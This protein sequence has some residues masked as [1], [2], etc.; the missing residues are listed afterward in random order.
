M[1]LERCPECGLLGAH[2]PACSKIA[3]PPS[4]DSEE[5]A[6][7]WVPVKPGE[8]VYNIKLGFVVSVIGI[9]LTALSYFSNVTPSGR[10]IFL[11][12]GSAILFG[13]SRF[14]LGIFQLFR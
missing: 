12:W 5:T 7:G 4:S 11:V 1:P 14:L 9:G 6:S 13:C 8:A 3:A 2:Q 10:G